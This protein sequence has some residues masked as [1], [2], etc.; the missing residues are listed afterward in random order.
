MPEIIPSPKTHTWDCGCTTHL[1]WRV[2]QV[3][4]KNND[5]E[6]ASIAHNMW[7]MGT[8]IQTRLDEETIQARL[9]EISEMA[10]NH[11]RSTNWS[12]NDYGH[13]LHFVPVDSCTAPHH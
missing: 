8:W 12:C 9:Q 3:P 6:H 2:H 11:R 7:L 5:R 13:M 10:Q 4:D 1:Y